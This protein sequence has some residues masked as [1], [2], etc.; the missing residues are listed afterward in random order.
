MNDENKEALVFFLMFML[1][2]GLVGRIDYQHALEQENAVL[3]A[4]CRSAKMAQ[5]GGV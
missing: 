4:S 2:L 5:R 1:L 3:K